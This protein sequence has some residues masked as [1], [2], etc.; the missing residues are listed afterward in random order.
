MPFGTKQDFK[1]GD[2]IS[3]LLACKKL[4]SKY[5]PKYGKAL[6]GFIGKDYWELDRSA[7]ELMARKY[8]DI[9]ISEAVRQFS[10]NEDWRQ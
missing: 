5:G 4:N 2:K 8:G 3:K 6:K 9:K 10:Q 7:L 1:P